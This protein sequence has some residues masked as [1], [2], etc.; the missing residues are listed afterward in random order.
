MKKFLLF[1]TSLLVISSGR[2]Q[3]LPGMAAR[4]AE[5]AMKKLWRDSTHKGP[6]PGRWSYDQSVVLLGIRGLWYRTA[7]ARYFDYM[8]QSMDRFVSEDGAI[9]TYRMD[10][11]NIDN[12]ACGRIL[13]DLY[14]VTGKDKYF[15]AA[16]TLRKQL[17][18]HP[19]TSEGSF[20]HKRIYPQ[21]VWLDGLYMAQP[22]LAQW[23]ATFNEGD[24][25]WNDIALQ[26]IN[27]ERQTRDPR[28]GLMRHGWD[29]SRKMP[30]ADKQ[31]GLSL[32]VWARAMGW[33]GAALADVLAY[34]PEGH[35]QRP[36]LVQIMERFAIA[37]SKAQDK[38]SGLWWDVMNAPYP[39]MK[40]N[41][42]ES[43]AAAQFVYALA[44]TTRL[45]L[46][47]AKYRQ[48]AEK[49]YQGIQ[50]KFIS[51]EATG[52][53]NYTGTVSVSGLGGKPYR[54]GT[55]AYYISERV[56]TNDPKG[57][58]AFIQ[59]ANEM[60]ILPDLQI[61]R[62]KT[63][64]LDSYYNDERGRNI[65][66]QNV[67]VHYKFSE[68]SPGGFSFL[69]ASLIRL[70]AETRELYTAPAAASLKGVAAYIIVD[71]DITKENPHAKM[72]NAADAAVIA[73]WVHRGGALVLLLNDVGNCDLD[74]INLLAEKFGFSFNS[75][76]RNRVQGRNF[77]QGAIR[78]SPE[79]P[80][81]R[82]AE[83]VY[84]KE[85][86]TIQVKDQRNVTVL[87]RDGTNVLMVSAKHGKGRVF[88]VGDPWLY[89]EYVDGRKLPSDFDNLKAADDLSRWMLND[90]S[91]NSTGT[92]NKRKKQTQ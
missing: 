68:T 54:D 60:E 33:Y 51:T 46:L 12:I 7:D 41:Y 77:T 10:D 19:R 91:F 30:W 37:I 39:G 15:K 79:N 65:L 21:Q 25:T 5:T 74:K 8:Q 9:D 88:A 57:M 64:L 78:L 92:A 24:S 55:F 32:N 89:N 16:A 4:V 27:I 87:E 28:S 72:M 81:F 45:G 83:K 56:I 2:A 63:V 53:T 13:L 3:Q 75:D 49:G 36:A 23:A 67:R 50:S 85:I 40:G 52:N 18:V 31:T 66:G 73:K 6:H 20:W 62:G 80:V 82:T 11:F 70:G 44:K 61:G 47:P 35:P 69:S 86:S 1:I 71:P 17:T 90:R 22:F 84:L 43:S 34:F 14:Q 48:V 29:E 42:F 38:K 26:F 76:S 59:A 58:G